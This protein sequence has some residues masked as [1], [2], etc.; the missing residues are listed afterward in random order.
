MNVKPLDAHFG[1]EV[2]GVDLG[3]DLDH[4]MM[5]QLTKALYSHRVIVI[6]DQHL[7]E[8]DYLTFGRAWGQP[9]PHVLDHL[10][11]RKSVV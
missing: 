1:A 2:L 9:I 10:R 11:D 4:A 7:D 8:H 5:Q 6:R 3:K